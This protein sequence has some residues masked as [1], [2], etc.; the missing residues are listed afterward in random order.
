MS[1]FDD[2]EFYRERTPR[3]KRDDVR[4]AVLIAAMVIIA[5]IVA[6]FSK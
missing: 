5:L 2:E 1:E 3:E 6:G 4:S